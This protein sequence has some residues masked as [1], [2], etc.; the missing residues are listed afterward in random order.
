MGPPLSMGPSP[1]L[2]LPSHNSSNFIMSKRT[3]NPDGVLIVSWEERLLKR[4]VKNKGLRSCLKCDLS[5]N[6]LGYY[7]RICPACTT[8]SR[9]GSFTEFH[10]GMPDL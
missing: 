1:N 9:A 2:D 10:E 5:F 7:N 4:A 3:I 6:S 8:R